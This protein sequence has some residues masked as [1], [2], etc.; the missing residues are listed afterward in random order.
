MRG[1]TFISLFLFAV[2]LVA[3]FMPLQTADADMG[4]K[5]TVQVQID[6]LPLSSYYV[7]LVS[8]SGIP[9]GGISL[10][11][12]EYIYHFDPKYKNQDKFV[13]RVFAEN[14]EYG[15]IGN[16]SKFDKATSIDYS[17]S[18]YAPSKFYIV[19]YDYEND[20]LYKSDH[21][22]RITFNSAYIASYEDFEQINENTYSFSPK[23][24]ALAMPLK[25]YSYEI[26]TLINIALFILRLVLTIAIELLIALAFKFNKDSYKI[27]AITNA[28]TQLFLNIFIWLMYYFAGGFGPFVAIFIGELIVFIVEPIVYKKKCLR[29]NG[30]QKL[31]VFYALLAN[32]ITLL[33]GVGFNIFELYIFS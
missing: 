17:W 24:L 10:K 9:S 27:I 7:G 16:I 23:G 4:P 21:I 15:T 5:P 14:F 11:E 29:E 28:A 12:D 13:E 6:G 25:K 22:N 31:I 19:I 1:K 18:Y 3:L 2:I 20:I 26:T 33:A 8:K 30:T 32:F